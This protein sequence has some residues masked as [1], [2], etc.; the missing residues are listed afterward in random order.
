M[1]ALMDGTAQWSGE[2]HRPDSLT[3]ERV[4]PGEAVGLL[5]ELSWALLRVW[6]CRPRRGPRVVAGC[7]FVDPHGGGIVGGVLTSDTYSSV[8]PQVAAQA[9]EA[10]VHLVPRRS[11]PSGHA[12]A[13]QPEPESRNTMEEIADFEAYRQVR[14][15]R[16]RWAV[17]DSNPEPTDLTQQGREGCRRPGG[18]RGLENAKS[19]GVAVL[20]C[21]T[22]R[23]TVAARQR[24]GRSIGGREGRGHRSPGRPRFRK[25][26]GV[27]PVRL[28]TRCRRSAVAACV[29]RGAGWQRSRGATGR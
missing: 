8:L 15:L 16:S 24:V 1:L 22:Q 2:G 23:S 28:R 9:A 14:D 7:R 17:R 29:L 4:K 18:V 21:C 6:A 25:R 26:G 20:R 5:S 13:T 27:E 3:T 11:G 19:V 12:M 10:V